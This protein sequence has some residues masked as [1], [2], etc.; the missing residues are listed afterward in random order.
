ME[1]NTSSETDLKELFARI[2]GKYND[3]PQAFASGDL[4][5]D[6]EVKIRAELATILVQEGDRTGQKSLIYDAIHH[7]DTILRRLPPTL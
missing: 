5:I 7:V 3:L 1:G 6:E 4:T 2:L